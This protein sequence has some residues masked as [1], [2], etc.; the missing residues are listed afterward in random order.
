MG[1]SGVRYSAVHYFASANFSIFYGWL[2]AAK[3]VHHELRPQS[4]CLFSVYATI[5]T[6]NNKGGHHFTDAHPESY[7][8]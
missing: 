3:S 5:F 2:Q 4:Y 7:D 1:D 8:L 6:Y